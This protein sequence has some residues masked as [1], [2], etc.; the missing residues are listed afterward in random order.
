MS[1]KKQ[2]LA[3]SELADDKEFL[4]ALEKVNEETRIAKERLSEKTY[5]NLFL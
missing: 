5:K 2:L 1:K 4:V 3:F